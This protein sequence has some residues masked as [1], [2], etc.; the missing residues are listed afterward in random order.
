[1]GKRIQRRTLPDFDCR[2]T[3]EARF[4]VPLAERIAM[5]RNRNRKREERARSLLKAERRSY[6]GQPAARPNAPSVFAGGRSARGKGP[7]P[8]RKG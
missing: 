3:S 5:I 2:H 4:Q 7:K 8:T 1:M 6:A